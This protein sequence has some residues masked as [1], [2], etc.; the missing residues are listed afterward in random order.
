MMLIWIGVALLVAA[1]TFV[2]L[3]RSAA[4]PAPLAPSGA[5]SAARVHAPVAEAARPAP[6]TAPATASMPAA[7]MPSSLAAFHLQLADELPEDRRQALVA[8][9]KD[10]PRPPK[11]LHR[12]LSP[13]FVNE[14]S[15]TQLV[16]MIVG[17]PL[18]AAQV[19]K[20][21]N[22]PMYGLKAPVSSIGQAVTYLGLNTVRGICLRYILIASFKADS[23]ERKQ[24]LDAAW[25]ASALASELTQQLSQ[26]L[27]FEDRGSLVSAVVLSFLGRLATT[28][29]MSHEQLAAIPA[30]GSL[31]R[32]AAEQRTLGL[33]S[34][35]IGRLLMQFWGL[36]TSLVE[37]AA[38]IDTVMVVPSSAFEAER[39]N[40]LAL[41][42][43]CARVGERLAE[44]RL[45]NLSGFNPQDA[46]DPELFHLQGHLARPPLA[47]LSQIVQ[48]P[49]MDL[50]MQQMLGA[51][52]R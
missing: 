44:R 30:Q 33:S 7:A 12:L 46:A 10:I 36:P 47:R 50:A 23:P 25:D 28:A 2:L 17:E 31:D 8:T 11:L 5:R 14:A 29:S 48:S 1:V 20:T 15:S 38:A 41:C 34:G 26:R 37:D 9:F 51:I 4:R 35:Q 22:S 42:F 45:A 32:M 19:L 21:I 16:D 43:V 18:I 13:D 39:G 49:D 52:R 27:G 24:R 40:R 3:K 6:A